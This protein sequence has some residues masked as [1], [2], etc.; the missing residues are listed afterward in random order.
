LEGIVNIRLEL[1]GQE[2]KRFLALKE[3]RGLK[4]NSEVVRQLLKEAQEREL[5]KEA[6]G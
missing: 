3:K 4:N 2:A 1:Q 5:T 6:K